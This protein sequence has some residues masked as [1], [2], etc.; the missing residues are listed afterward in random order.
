MRVTCPHPNRRD[1]LAIGG[2]LAVKGAVSPFACAQ[3]QGG[4]R[5]ERIGFFFVSDTHYY[6]DEERLD[7]LDPRSLK[8]TTNLISTLNRLPGSEIPSDAGGGLVMEPRGVIHGGDLIDS[9]DKQGKKYEAMQRVEWDAYIEDFGTDGTDGRLRYPSYEVYG[10]HDSPHGQ[11]LVI[12]GLA[13][14]NRQRKGLTGLSANGL[15]CSWDWGPIHFLNLGIVVGEASGATQRRRYAP[16]DSLTFLTDDLQRHVGTSDRPV[17]ITHHID[18]ARYSKPCNEEDP[19]HLNHEWHPCDVRSYYEAIAST[20]VI[21]I[22]YGHTHVRNTLYWN[23]E[24]A[25]GETGIS[26]FNAD[27][28]SH[29]SGG[30]Q[31]FFY[32]EIGRGEMIVR[33]CVTRDNWETMTWTPQVWRRAIS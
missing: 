6:A 18:I 25:R 5:D 28:G 13:T 14:R 7:R 17:I 22:L 27:N 23:G 15:H 24:S 4:D 20:N 19:V 10:N 31:A 26:V 11:G 33:E 32:M 1:F 30:N 3:E 21:A 2:A 8:V 29:F 9:G 16:M 12:E